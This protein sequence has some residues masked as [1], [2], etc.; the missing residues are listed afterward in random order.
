MN[1]AKKRYK[2]ISILCAKD[3][4]VF[5]MVS[6]HYSKASLCFESNQGFEGI[7]QML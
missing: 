7:N 2:K 6:I 1:L 3:Q 4:P 5:K